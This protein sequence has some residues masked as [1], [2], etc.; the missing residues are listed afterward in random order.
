MCKSM[1]VEDDRLRRKQLVWGVSIGE[2]S[3][4]YTEAYIRSQ[5]DLVN[6][7]VG[8]RDIVAA[9][10]PEYSSVNIWYNDSGRAVKRVDFWGDSDQGQLKRVE[11]VK[12]GLYWFVWIN[13]FPESQLNNDG[14]SRREFTHLFGAA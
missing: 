3:M 9:Y 6:A 7:R 11:T 10:D 13:Y 4:A 8:G 5:G 1:D 14:V 2:E 12:A